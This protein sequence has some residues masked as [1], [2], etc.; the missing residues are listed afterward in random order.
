MEDLS[1]AID[2]DLGSLLEDSHQRQDPTPTQLDNTEELLWSELHPHNETTDALDALSLFAL[3]VSDTREDAWGADLQDVGATSKRRRAEND[4]GWFAKDKRRE[5]CAQDGSDRQGIHELPFDELAPYFPE[6]F[7]SLPLQPLAG[8]SLPV[9]N[10]FSD[11]C[12]DRYSSALRLTFKLPVDGGVNGYIKF[13]IRKVQE[14]V[15]PRQ[16]EKLSKTFGG[17]EMGV[18]H[19]SVPTLEAENVQLL[20]RDFGSSCRMD[21]TEK[22]LFTFCTYPYSVDRWQFSNLAV[23]A[24]TVAF[25]TGRT[26]ITNSNFWL[27][28]IA[29]VADQNSCVRNALLASTAAYVL[30]YMPNDLPLRRRANMHYNHA[31]KLLTDALAAEVTSTQVY[32]REIPVVATLLLLSC[33]D[34]SRSLLLTTLSRLVLT[35]SGCELGTEHTP[36]SATEMA[37]GGHHGQDHTGQD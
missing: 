31:V 14:A 21:P 33:D 36:E 24:D 30:D 7:P 17:S 32:D 29:A 26:L 22:K 27:K 11:G 37:P 35:D 2:L 6:L 5:A 13:R 1:W 12:I 18:H 8:H 25:C 16:K 15:G 28:D 3:D 19:R 9:D 23:G 20:P 34:V 4:D 10:P